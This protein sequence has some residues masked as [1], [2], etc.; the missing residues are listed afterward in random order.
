MHPI[1]LTFSTLRYALERVN[2]SGTILFETKMYKN[3]GKYVALQ[4]HHWFSWLVC[5]PWLVFSATWTFC[6]HF[7]V[8]TA[9]KA[10]S[11]YLYWWKSQLLLQSKYVCSL[12]AVSFPFYVSRAT[13]Q[14]LNYNC[15]VDFTLII[16]LK[17]IH[18]LLKNKY[19]FSYIS[20]KYKI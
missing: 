7:P 6:S 11:L 10:S 8:G 9:V 5:Q 18:P 14:Q 15:M 20:L 16:K 4:M 19:L 17:E 1:Y 13:M 3:I 12:L 2:N